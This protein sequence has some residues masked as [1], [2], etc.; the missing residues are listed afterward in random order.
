VSSA[1]PVPEQWQCDERTERHQL[2]PAE[3]RHPDRD[4]EPNRCNRPGIVPAPVRGEDHHRRCED[5]PSSP[6]APSRPASRSP[7]T[8]QRARRRRAR[9]ACHRSAALRSRP[10]HRGRPQ[11]ARPQLVLEERP[12]PEQRSSRQIDDV[13]GRVV[14]AGDLL[15]RE[16]QCNRVGKPMA[17]G[18]QVRADVV[19][20]RVIVLP[21][22]DAPPMTYPSLTARPTATMAASHRCQ[23]STRTRR[24]PR[25][26][27][28]ESASSK[29]LPQ[30]P[31]TLG[32]RISQYGHVSPSWP[33]MRATLPSRATISALITRLRA[34]HGSWASWRPTLARRAPPANGS[35]RYSASDRLRPA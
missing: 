24:R 16:R 33:S 29:R 32:E 23:V 21:L 27:P 6:T 4:A 25:G 20:D 34:N 18:K 11:E 31:R 26:G 9:R 30:V 2:G 17:V 1:P 14:R 12:Q 13:G 19:V 35:L 7:G 5:G 8:P 22:G 28:A 15:G 10:T 3:R